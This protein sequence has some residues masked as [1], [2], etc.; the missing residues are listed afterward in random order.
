MISVEI[1]VFLF[2]SIELSLE[3]IGMIL[4]LKFSKEVEI[5]ALRVH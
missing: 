3:A 5:A 4:K 1:E 2:V